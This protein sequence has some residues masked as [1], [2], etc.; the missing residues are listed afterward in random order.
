M[1]NSKKQPN[2]PYK[3]KVDRRSKK[4]RDEKVQSE[5]LQRYVEYCKGNPVAILDKEWKI[6]QKIRQLE[7][8]IQKTKQKISWFEFLV[9]DEYLKSHML[10]LRRMKRIGELDANFDIDLD[11]KKHVLGNR[12]TLTKS[13][14]KLDTLQ[15]LYDNGMLERFRSDLQKLERR[16]IIKMIESGKLNIYDKHV[17]A[18]VANEILAM[19]KEPSK[20]FADVDYIKNWKD[21]PW[22]DQ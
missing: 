4:A 20:E 19:R 17:D 12:I 5:L 2:K 13:Q 22:E 11:I 10:F 18:Y 14:M 6:F 7:T 3:K 8:N 21:V 9:S 15:G 16:R 1:D